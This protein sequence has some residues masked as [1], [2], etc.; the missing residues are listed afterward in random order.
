MQLDGGSKIYLEEEEDLGEEQEEKEELG[1]GSMIHLVQ[2]LSG[3]GGGLSEEQ[4]GR[5]WWR[6]IRTFVAY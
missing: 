2:D 3:G 5:T 4:K 1:D 6:S